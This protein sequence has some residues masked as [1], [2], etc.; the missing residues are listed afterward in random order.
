MI[1]LISAKSQH[2]VEQLCAEGCQSVRAYIARL[3]RGE[4]VPQVADLSHEERQQVLAE[5]RAIMAVY[6]E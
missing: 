5:L 3:E 1:L 4:P 6:D 2:C